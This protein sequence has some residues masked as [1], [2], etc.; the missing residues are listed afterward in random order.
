MNSYQ[1]MKQ[2]RKT[3]R[4]WNW[5]DDPTNGVLFDPKSVIIAANAD[6]V[7]GKQLVFPACVISP[8]S[9]DMDP[10][11]RHDPNLILW[12]FQI[13]LMM[14]NAN[15]QFGQAAIIGASRAAALDSSVG[16]GLEE[17]LSETRR[18]LG[19]MLPS[20]GGMTI[21]GTPIDGA[22]IITDPQ[23]RLWAAY[24]DLSVEIWGTAQR[25]YHPADNLRGTPTTA[26]PVNLAW[27]LPPDRFDL[28]KLVLCRAAGSTAPTDPAT[29]VVATFSLPYS[30]MATT[31]ADDPPGSGTFSYA[32]FAQYDDH[33]ETPA[34]ANRTA[35]AATV[36]VVAL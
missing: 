25:Y 7:A 9:D 27:S 13:R 17:I 16:R 26:G 14:A 29:G 10:E 22:G 30:T 32:L 28:L 1:A 2:M 23:G 34:T 21:M 12:R 4:D 31:Y 36:T 24:R 8:I 3:L 18:A 15:D 35:S 11:T 6:E 19:Q 5:E 20:T 33:A